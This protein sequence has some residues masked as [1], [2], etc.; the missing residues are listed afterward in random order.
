[1]RVT[2]SRLS[3]RLLPIAMAAVLAACGNGPSQQQNADAVNGKAEAARQAELDARAAELAR[4]EAEVTA[5]ELEQE[6]ARL[7]EEAETAKREQAEKEAA[8]KKAAARKVAQA[9]LAA[10]RQSATAQPAVMRTEAARASSPET[11]HVQAGTQ[12]D[13]ALSSELSS[14]TSQVGETFEGRVTS[15]LLVGDRVAIPAGTRVVGS[16]AEVISGSNSVGAIPLL[17]LRID[18]VEFGDGRSI[19]IHGEFQQQGQSEKGRDAAKII[20]GAAAGAVLGHQVRNDNRGKI[21]GGLLGAA[22]GTAIAKKTG[23]EVQL[24]VGSQLNVVLS[25]GFSVTRS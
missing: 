10:A 1:M 5:K 9:R 13:I 18:R 25:D 22:A 20:G 21:I 2:S 7:R 24:P 23:T 8:A 15:D 6:N 17:A 16:V 3:I 19:P 4:R 14:K 11:L 12:L